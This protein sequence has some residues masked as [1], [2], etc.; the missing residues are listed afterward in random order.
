M[1]NLQPQKQKR[2]LTVQ[3]ISCVGQC[4]LT[5]ALPIIS[6]FGIETVM[7]PSAVLSTHTGSW[8]GFTFRD[9]TDDIPGIVS[10]WEKEG[11]DFDAIYTGYIGN[12]RQIDMILGMRETLLVPN[13]PIITDPAMA[14][15]GVL[16]TGFDKAFVESMKKL[17]GGS[18]YLLPNITEAAMLTG[19]EYKEKYDEE[20]ILGL[21]RELCAIGAKNVVLTG[22][23]FE[24]GQI[25]VY[26]YDGKEARYCSQERLAYNKHGT[27]DVYASV[28]SG[29]L[30]SGESAFDAAKKA[31][32]FTKDAMINTPSDHVYGV[33][34]EGILNKITDREN[35]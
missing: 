9:L 32:T 8:K 2:L 1:E 17:V 6:A 31:A 13:A 4:S 24:Q 25:G 29:Y 27:G 30:V 20:Y 35:I 26:V 28:F 22:V 16:Y 21:C 14:D 5:V 34:F 12:A 11:I 15:N 33:N 10:H 18:D 3:D 19:M 23:C 7:L